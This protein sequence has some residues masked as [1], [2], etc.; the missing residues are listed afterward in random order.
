MNSDL[1]EA[2]SFSAKERA[3]LTRAARILEAKIRVQSVTLS[4]PALVREWLALQFSGLEQEVFGVIYLDGQNRLIDFEALFA[5]TLTRTSVYPREVV[6]AA[7]GRNAASVMFVHNHPSGC[8][9]P[10]HADQLL[11]QTLKPSL[12]MVDIKVLDHFI[13]GGRAVLSFAPNAESSNST[14]G[15]ASPLPPPFVSARVR[16]PTRHLSR[17]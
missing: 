8:A 12:G 9:E 13:V 17:T 7:L 14:E 3:V 5:G 2:S 15:A 4:S 1:L 6:K 16:F 11:T 10:S